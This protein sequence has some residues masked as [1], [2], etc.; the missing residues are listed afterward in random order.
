MVFDNF[1]EDSHLN[2]EARQCGGENKHMVVTIRSLFS[3]HLSKH[4]LDR[5][6]GDVRTKGREMGNIDW[7]R[8]AVAS[9]PPQRTRTFSRYWI[10]M[11]YDSTTLVELC[12]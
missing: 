10:A 3:K 4:Y 2:L 11:F 1:S 12:E 9:V 7:N 5:M 6:A 8:Q